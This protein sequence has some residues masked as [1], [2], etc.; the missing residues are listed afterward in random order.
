MLEPVP[1]SGAFNHSEQTASAFAV[2][3]VL[4]VLLLVLGVYPAPVID[5]IEA[6]SAYI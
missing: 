1:E 6:I 3:S 2:V 5:L 4:L